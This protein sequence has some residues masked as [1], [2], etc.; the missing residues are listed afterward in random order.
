MRHKMLV[1]FVFCF[2]LLLFA[3]STSP[4]DV[5]S[6]YKGK[7][8]TLRHAY[9][10]NSQH[11]DAQGNALKPSKEG[12]WTLYGRLQITDIKL[13]ND[14]LEIRGRRTGLANETGYLSD[15]GVGQSP[16]RVP[17]P[18]GNSVSI[19]VEMPAGADPAS[20]LGKV[21]A[22]TEEDLLAS[23]PDLW[24]PYV[25][26][27]LDP[28]SSNGQWEFTPGVAA[29]SRFPKAGTPKPVS[30]GTQH[31]AL[32][33]P[34]VVPP[35]PKYTPTPDYGGEI[36][37]ALVH[38]TTTFGVTI[39]PGGKITSVTIINPIGLGVDESAAE[40]LEKKWRFEP[41]RLNGKP[42]PTNLM[43]EMEYRR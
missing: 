17:D 23:V 10:S 42:V 3:Q 32:N 25:R 31:L 5:N 40:T 7:I 2:T 6:Q 20:L 4:Q 16:L 1:P 37:R 26:T 41:G 15:Y 19:R 34:G 9:R 14:T 11:Y 27:R 29:D 43:L 24:K 18:I 36:G 21:F 28:R 38:G 22:L 12:P 30:A 13:H 35:K 39:D 33:A 8:L